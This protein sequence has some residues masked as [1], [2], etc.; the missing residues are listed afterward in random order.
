MPHTRPL[1]RSLVIATLLAVLAPLLVV[2]LASYRQYQH[3]VGGVEAFVTQ[4]AAAGARSAGNTVDLLLDGTRLA[5]G[6]VRRAAEAG[7]VTKAMLRAEVADLPQIRSLIVTDA[8]GKILVS[9]R[10]EEGRSVSAATPVAEILAG[11][12]IAYSDVY[13]SP[14][15]GVDAVSVAVPWVG[16]R[17]R[18]TVMARMSTAE[19]NRL[20]VNRMEGDLRSAY[21]FVTDRR[22]RVIAHP[23]PTVPVGADLSTNPPVAA[24]MRGGRG[25]LKYDSTIYGA[26]RIAGYLSVPAAGWAVVSARETGDQMVDAAARFQN[27]LIV[28]LVAGLLAAAAAAAYGRKLVRPL[29]ALAGTMQAARAGGLNEL[30][31]P[32]LGRAAVDTDVREYAILGTAYNDMAEALDR[33]VQEILALNEEVQAQNEE[34]QAQNEELQAQSE[35]LQA[36]TEEIQAQSEEL[37]AQTEVLVAQNEDL[38]RL[39]TEAT[40]ANRMKSEFLANMSHELRTPLNSIIGYAELIIHNKKYDLPPKVTSHLGTVL[41]NARNLLT[42]INDILDLSKVE[43]GKSTVFAEPLAL[44]PFVQ[45]ILTTTEPLARERG[46]ALEAEVAPGLDAV[47]T[48]ETKLRQ[49]VLNLVSN[50][51]KFT[52]EGRVALRVVP[53]GAGR[54][55]FEVEDTGVG[56]AP[57]LHDAVFEEFRQVDGSTT[58]EVGGTGLG[59]PIARRL[60]R[61]LGGDVALRRSVPGEGS[62]FVATIAAGAASEGPLAAAQAVA[63]AGGERLVVSIDDDPDMLLLLAERLKDTGYRVV[64]ATTGPSGLALVRE[65]RPYAV[66][67]DVLM[68]G[69]DGWSVLRALKGDPETADVPVI[70]LSFIEDKLLGFELGAAAYL[71]KPVEQRDLLD[72]LDRF[73]SALG[74]G[75]YVLVVDDDADARGI[76]AELLDREGIRHREAVDGRSALAEIEREAPALLILDLMMPHMDGFEVAAW[77]R[78][79]PATAA[80]PVIVVSGKALTAEDRARL[81]DVKRVIPKGDGAPALL[82]EDLRALLDRSRPAVREDAP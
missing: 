31:G 54:V 6:R 67:V 17:G 9:D 44:R 51:L 18:G 23:D 1:A 11:S 32:S 64:P 37:Q 7:A 62:L 41:R 29:E 50:A 53:A 75:G 13:R 55:A 3:D 25:T 33:R 58:R 4:E 65:L 12:P 57:E 36:Q 76:Y 81:A 56:I 45:A 70:V 40:A 49:V 15:L 61:M 26:P 22:G 63:A 74:R 69:M 52:R 47:V 24:A 73:A 80:I 60:A 59:L 66:T 38:A 78:R 39:S 14:S 79:D 19:L 77:L 42:L 46:V 35:E 72:A 5:L 68:P 16:P 30:A 43:A 48:D 21:T 28:T 82:V 8:A 34:L 71:S 10:H 20:L 27:L 2:A